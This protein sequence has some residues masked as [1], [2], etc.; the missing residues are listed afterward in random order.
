MLNIVT[1]PT[2]R[3]GQSP[4][5]TTLAALQIQLKSTIHPNGIL[6]KLPIKTALE[7]NKTLTLNLYF[8]VVNNPNATD[9]WNTNHWI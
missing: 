9:F 3:P 5:F 6:R 4:T 1:L 2:D 7:M 8:V